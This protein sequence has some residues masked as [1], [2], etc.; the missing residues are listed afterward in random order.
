[1]FICSF[2]RRGLDNTFSSPLIRNAPVE[3]RILNN[4]D[5]VAYVYVGVHVGHIADAP[6]PGYYS[7]PVNV[8][9]VPAQHLRDYAALVSR[10]FNIREP[11][12]PLE[13]VLAQFLEQNP[14][15]DDIGERDINPEA[16]DGV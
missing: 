9:F 11:P 2:Y 1:M 7:L 10:Y 8:E 5:F 13:Q 14:V 4:P 15:V 12:A 6:I 16:F 3:I